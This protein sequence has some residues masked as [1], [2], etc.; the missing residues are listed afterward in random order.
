MGG[1]GNDI[2]YGE[3][4]AGTPSGSPL[5]M[6]DG[7]ET[8]IGGAG[9]DIIYENMGGDRIFG[10]GDSDTIYGGQDDDTIIGGDGSDGLYGNIGDDLIY[11]DNLFSSANAGIDTIDGATGNDSAVY[12]SD[13]SH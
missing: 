10:Q 4:N 3:Q 13:Y 8:L 6:R 7:V 9:A 11:G 1:A 12:L 5:R 2:I